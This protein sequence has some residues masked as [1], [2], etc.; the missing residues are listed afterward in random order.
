[1]RTPARPL[2]IALAPFLAGCFTTAKPLILPEAADYPLKEGTQ[3][4]TYRLH[5]RNHQAERDGGA[6]LPT[7]TITVPGDGKDATI[8]A[9][10]LPPGRYYAGSELAGQ[11]APY[12]LKHVEGPYYVLETWVTPGK[13]KPAM[14]LYALAKIESGTTSTYMLTCHPF[15]TDSRF[16]RSG[17][18]HLD[19]KAEYPYCV[20]N[21]L[22]DLEAVFRARIAGGALPEMVGV[23]K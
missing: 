12:L 8:A 9:L 5:Y 15:D 18:L 14:I 21:S 23:E 20:P 19:L 4:A 22:D 17:Q 7:Q 13:S 2:A 3:Y 11:P 16:L 6:V 1:M 10:G